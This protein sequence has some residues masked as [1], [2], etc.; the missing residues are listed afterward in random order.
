MN[1]GKVKMNSGKREVKSESAEWK[2]GKVLCILC[3]YMF[4]LVHR[5]IVEAGGV[6]LYIYIYTHVVVGGVFVNTCI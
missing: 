3:R 5:D 1:S 6:C 4:M 2:R